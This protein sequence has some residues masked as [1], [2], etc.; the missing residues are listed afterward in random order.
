M[1]AAAFQGTDLLVLCGG[2]PAVH[3]FSG[4]RHHA[5]GARGHAPPELSRPQNVAW[6][7]GRILVRDS[8]LQKIVAYDR[9]GN[10]LSN[11]RLPPGMAVRLEMAGRDTLLEWFGPEAQLVVRLRGSRQDTLLRYAAVSETIR[12]SAPGA[13]SL[14]LPPPYAALPLWTPLAD[15]RLAFWDGRE[16]ALRL[17]DRTGR[18]AGRLPLP[19][20]RHPVTQA[21]RE[22]WFASGIPADIRGQRVFEPLRE[23]AREQVRFP[24]HFPA[25]LALL[26]DPG[27]GVWVQRTATAGGQRW[28]YLR[29]GQP[30]LQVHFPAGHRLLAVG[31]RD[32]AVLAGEA[33]HLYTKPRPRATA[34]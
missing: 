29:G 9:D 1:R 14:S 6:A 30:P 10:L 28:A 27:G 25:A 32:M 34:R 12:L 24:Q 33:I 19:A 11:R 13:P 18:V 7:G 20:G 17:L 8:E 26:P 22:A 21:D 5:W 31:E 2:A 23:R 16:P 15:G 3:L 4:G